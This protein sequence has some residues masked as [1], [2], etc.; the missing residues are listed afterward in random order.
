MSEFI[1]TEF[2]EP[3]FSDHSSDLLVHLYREIGIAAVAAALHIMAEPVAPQN[4]AISD[5]GRTSIPAFLQSDNV[6]A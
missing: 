4:V 2:A 1:T 5:E 3:Q 6:A